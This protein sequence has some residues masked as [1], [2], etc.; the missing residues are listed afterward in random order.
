M[1][2]A[3][4]LLLN[5][6][7]KVY[8]AFLQGTFVRY[9]FIGLYRSVRL[10]TEEKEFPTEIANS[11]FSVQN[12]YNSVVIKVNRYSFVEVCDANTVQLKY[13]SWLPNNKINVQ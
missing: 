13:K 11:I 8:P 2:L 12:S 4:V 6:S 9:N 5:R 1:Y 10:T 7:C 3:E